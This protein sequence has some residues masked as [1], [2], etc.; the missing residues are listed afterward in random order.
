MYKVIQGTYHNEEKGSYQSYGLQNQERGILLEDVC[1]NKE[2]M[3]GF[4]D[5]LN[6]NH[7]S[8]EDFLIYIEDFLAGY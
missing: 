8:E 4:I 1:L 6:R 2:M 3:Q 7:V 5:R